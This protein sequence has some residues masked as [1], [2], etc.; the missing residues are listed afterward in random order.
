LTTPADGSS[1]ASTLISPST[2]PKSY[3]GNASTPASPATPMGG[4]FAKAP[5][6]A[7]PMTPLQGG[8]VTAVDALSSPANSQKPPAQQ[9]LLLAAEALTDCATT[10][11][12]SSSSTPVATASVRNASEATPTPD[13]E[14]T[15][16]PGACTEDL[17]RLPSIGLKVK[18]S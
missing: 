5:S 2:P 8:C 17:L 9:P 14:A 6:P 10:F 1:E 18:V 3:C 4:C 12:G 13:S 11:N 7:S 16:T 15:P